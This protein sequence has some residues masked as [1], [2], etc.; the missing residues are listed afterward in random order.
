MN[1]RKSLR[2]TMALATPILSACRAP[3][4]NPAPAPA[5]TAATAATTATTATAAPATV[6]PPSAHPPANWTCAA[7]CLGDYHCTS[8]GDSS[9]NLR[10]VTSEAPTAAAAYVALARQCTT[11]SDLVAGGRCNGGR[12][13]WH[14]A[15]MAHVCAR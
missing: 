4:T 12:M 7:F 5:P 14:P 8:E 9:W 15:P 2:T 11:N 6:A 10:A 13:E 3:Q 1:I